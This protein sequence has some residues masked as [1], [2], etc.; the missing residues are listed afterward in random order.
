MQE[1]D[2]RNSRIRSKLCIIYISSNND[3]HPVTKTFT[4]LHYTSPNYTS[5]NYTSLKYIC[6]HFTSF[7]LNFPSLHFTTLQYPLI[8]LNSMYISYRSTS[9][10]F[11]SLHF[12]SLLDDFGTL[13]FLSLRPICNCSPNLMLIHWEQRVND[14]G[15]LIEM[16]VSYDRL[17]SSSLLTYSRAI[18]RH[19]FK[20]GQ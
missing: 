1:C 7:H 14:N 15:V 8:W 12:T 3:R 2:K 4:P 5:P 9:L 20:K 6:R 13:L 18:W 10:H 19:S 17:A 11:T 16:R